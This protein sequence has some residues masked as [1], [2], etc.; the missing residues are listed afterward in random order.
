MDG[1]GYNPGPC[2]SQLSGNTQRYVEDSSSDK[3]PP[4]I[5]PADHAIDAYLGTERELS[6]GARHGVFVEA[7]S[8]GCFG[9]MEII[10][11]PTALAFCKARGWEYIRER[12]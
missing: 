10:T 3:R 5:D 8:G 11:N 6:M 12:A 9:T 4:V 1:G 2:H 7:F